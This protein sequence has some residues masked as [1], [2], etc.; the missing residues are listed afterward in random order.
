M[1][2]KIR[3][4]M[5]HRDP[6]EHIWVERDEAAVVGTARMGLGKATL[7]GSPSKICLTV[8]SN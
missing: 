3:E 4:F 7:C 6:D 2:K 8:R 1:G 5:T